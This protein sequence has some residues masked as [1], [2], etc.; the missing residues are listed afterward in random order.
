MAGNTAHAQRRDAITADV[1][2]D[3]DHLDYVQ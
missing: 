1:I 2:E 3:L